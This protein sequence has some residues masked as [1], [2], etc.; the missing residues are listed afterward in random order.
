MITASSATITT[1]TMTVRTIAGYAWNKAQAS[2]GTYSGLDITDY[3][4]VV[5]LNKPSG[6]IRI[7]VT[8]STKWVN[9]AGTVITNNTPVTAALSITVKFA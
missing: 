5:S 2:G 3:S 4:P 1:G 9:N 6:T 8:N 7:R